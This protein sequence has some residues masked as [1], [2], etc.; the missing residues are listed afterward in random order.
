MKFKTV[1]III[2][3]IFILSL[4]IAG[5]LVNRNPYNEKWII[6]KTYEQVVE[7]YGEF[8]GYIAYKNS[9]GE[10]FCTTG[11]YILK[12]RKTGFLGTT[13]ATYFRIDFDLDGIAYKCYEQMERGW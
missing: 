9:N 8:D 6:G 4:V 3:L 13:P 7:K 5:I 1:V 12:P 11:S 2:V 10:P